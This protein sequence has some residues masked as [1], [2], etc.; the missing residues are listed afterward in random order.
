[1]LRRY[2]KMAFLLNKDELLSGLKGVAATLAAARELRESMRDPSKQASTLCKQVVEKIMQS[3][4]VGDFAPECS[5]AS[6]MVAE[7]GFIRWRVLLAFAA[8]LCLFTSPCFSSASR[9]D[10]IETQPKS[11]SG[12][13]IV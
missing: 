11:T 1:M 12:R 9:Y 2:R 4:G 10:S 13:P 6:A 3:K 5:Q 8:C 7:C